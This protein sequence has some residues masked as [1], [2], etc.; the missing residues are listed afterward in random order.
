MVTGYNPQHTLTDLL[1]FQTILDRSVPSE[2]KVHV[3]LDN[4]RVPKGERVRRWLCRHPRHVFPFVP[5]GS[6]GMNL[7]E[8]GWGHR[9]RPALR[10]GSFLSVS[11]LGEAIEGY[12]KASNDAAH[13]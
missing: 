5:T 13:P 4:L 12:A 3:V 7:V 6:S 1:S 9:Q 2:L 11:E 10:R 8:G